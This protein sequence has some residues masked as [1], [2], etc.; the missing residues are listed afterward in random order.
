MS[1]IFIKTG[2]VTWHIDSLPLNILS[3]I[4]LTEAWK[5]AWMRIFRSTRQTRGLS[6]RKIQN[7]LSPIKYADWWIEIRLG[8][9]QS[10]E[11]YRMNPQ[12]PFLLIITIFI[13][14]IYLEL[15]QHFDWDMSEV[16]RRGRSKASSVH[17]TS[18]TLSKNWWY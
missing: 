1:N 6:F 3:T 7:E 8:E 18:S 10:S 5:E 12:N 15:I 14:L 17:R 4:E 9:E 13:T 2:I 11:F 16:F